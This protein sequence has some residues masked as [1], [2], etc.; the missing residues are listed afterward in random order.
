MK[1]YIAGALTGTPNL[2]VLRNLYESV[3]KLCLELGLEPYVPH[4]HS[5][6]IKNADLT[7]AEVDK[8]DRAKIEESDMIILYAGEP[9]LGTGI[10]AEIANQ[11]GRPV[12][13]FYESGKKI[14]RLLL[15]NPAVVAALTFTDRE[16]AISSLRNFL[17]EW[18]A[19]K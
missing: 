4:L 7:P 13:L 12:V 8:M 15:G 1:I 9:S 2:E 10:E 6:P 16:D 11:I 19:K 17:T 5:D 14:S 18:I 3:A